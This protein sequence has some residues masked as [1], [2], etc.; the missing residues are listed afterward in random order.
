MRTSNSHVR[1]MPEAL[2]SQVAAGEVV[3]R[4]ASVVKEL[5]ENAL[6][7]GARRVEVLAERGGA[8]LLRVVDDGSGMAREDAILAVERHAT[9]K[10]ATKEDLAKIRTYGFRGEALPSIASVSRFRLATREHGAVSGTE[11]LIDGG[12]LIE[13]RECGDP[14][15]TGVEVRGLFYNVPARRKFLR[16][17]ATEFAHIEAAV[18]VAALARPDVAFTLRHGRRLVFQVGSARGRLERIADLAGADLAESLLAVEGTS[19]AD[20]WSVEGWVGRPGQGRSGRSMQYVFLNGRPIEAAPVSIGVREAYAGLMERGMH[21]AVFLFLAGDPGDFDINVHPAKREVRIHR[22]RAVQNLVGE[23]VRRALLGLGEPRASTGGSP[24]ESA[25]SGQPEERPAWKP[26]PLPAAQRHLPLHTASAPEA[27]DPP[28]APGGDAPEAGGGGSLPAPASQPSGTAA[29]FRVL[30]ALGAR[31]LVLE[32]E[33]GLVLMHRRAAHERVLFEEAL[34]A[35]ESGGVQSQSLLSPATLKLGP[36]DYRVAVDHAGALDRLGVGVE[37]F[38]VNT[39]KVDRLPA[40]CGGTDPGAFVTALVADIRESGAKAGRRAGERELAAAV[41]SRAARAGEAD[42]R[43]EWDALVE[44]LMACEMP[45]CDAR[46]RPTLI[47]FSHQEL[48]RRF[49]IR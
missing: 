30:G 9:S 18:R 21:P 33:E 2:A 13:V 26:L 28:A 44:R 8:S 36:E 25:G 10:L 24:V 38:G 43:E 48:A 22:P 37:P 20:G 41:S 32:G 49:S 29:R 4:P 14:P 31:Y 12:K 16:A 35:A 5:V 23:A 42:H 27:A 46:G 17:E 1:V 7:A 47:Q 3:E 45:Y 15:G 11:V 40:F 19:G 6:D 34:T 39:L